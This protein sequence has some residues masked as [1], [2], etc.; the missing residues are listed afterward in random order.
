VSGGIW[1]DAVVIDRYTRAQAIADG[2]LVDVSEAA[3]KRGIRVPVAVSAAAWAD[4]CEWTDRR[5]AQVGSRSACG[6]W[7]GASRAC[8]R[9]TC[10]P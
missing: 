8:R 6:A 4:A 1:D 10:T 2:L 5:P 9:A 3:R 7:S